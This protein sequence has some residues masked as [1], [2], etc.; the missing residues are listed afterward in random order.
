MLFW[1]YTQMSQAI[2]EGFG[3]ISYLFRLHARAFNVRNRNRG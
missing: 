3:S 1:A 2:L